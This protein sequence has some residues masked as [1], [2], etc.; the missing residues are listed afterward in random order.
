MFRISTCQL[1]AGW[2][3]GGTIIGLS[4]GSS[5]GGGSDVMFDGRLEEFLAVTITEEYT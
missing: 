4:D 1:T 5:H 2:R 3:V